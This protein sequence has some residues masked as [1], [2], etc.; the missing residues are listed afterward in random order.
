LLFQYEIFI[1]ENQLQ[2]QSCIIQNKTGLPTARLFSIA[3]IY[4]YGTG[5]S[6]KNAKNKDSRENTSRNNINN[7]EYKFD[8]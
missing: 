1:F 8:F 4:A 5:F 6:V 3:L 7:F 2:T